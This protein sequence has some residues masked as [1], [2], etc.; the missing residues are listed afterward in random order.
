MIFCIFTENHFQVHSHL[1]GIFSFPSSFNPLNIINYIIGYGIRITYH[2]HKTMNTFYG[3]RKI[4]ISMIQWKSN[5]GNK[6]TSWEDF[7]I[8]NNLL[9]NYYDTKRSFVILVWCDYISIGFS[10][11]NNID[12]QFFF[13]RFLSNSCALIF[14]VLF[15]SCSL[16]FEGRKKMVIKRWCIGH[17]N[18]NRRTVWYVVRFNKVW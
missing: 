13:G 11:Q 5:N 18:M 9:S 16:L 8:E 2:I 15:R 1:N 4:A 12:R 14:I 10:I 3:Q 7:R 6:I 17:S